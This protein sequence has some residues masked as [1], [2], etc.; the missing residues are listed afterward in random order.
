M[1]I[2]KSLPQ[3]RQSLMF[4]ATM[5][6]KIRSLAKEILNKPEEVSVAISK[7]AEGVTQKVY[8]A[9]EEQR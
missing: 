3:K 2:I 4:S 6:P 1:K 7:P 5:A 8:L 9:H